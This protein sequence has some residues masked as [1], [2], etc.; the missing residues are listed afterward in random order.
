MQE[1]KIQKFLDEAVTVGFIPASRMFDPSCLK[2]GLGRNEEFEGMRE[3]GDNGHPARLALAKWLLQTNPF[4]E[5]MGE[6]DKNL[7]EQGWRGFP[8]TV[9]V[10][11][12]KDMA[13]PVEMSECLVG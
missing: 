5:L 11:G 2:A 8:G 1:S 9:L 10:H 6:M 13:V 4:P 3:E 12:D 7:E